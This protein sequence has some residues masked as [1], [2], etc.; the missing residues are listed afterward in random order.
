V[1]GPFAAERWSRDRLELFVADA[2]P[3]DVAYYAPGTVI[4]GGW[5]WLP[6]SARSSGTGVYLLSG[7]ASPTAVVPPFA[8]VGAVADWKSAMLVA[9]HARRLIGVILLR[10][11]HFAVG[12]VD[13]DSV[14]VSRAGH[15]YVH[16]RHRAGGQSQRRWERNREQWIEALFERACGTWEDVTRPFSGRLD[17]L[18]L[19]GDRTVL[20]RFRKSCQAVA[21]LHHIE[22]AR[23]VPVDRPD[24]AAIEKA[25]VAIWSSNVYRTA[26]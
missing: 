10:L 12:V 15:R 17:H 11:G 9:L 8:P 5:D 23:R 22:V 18:A 16:G 24:A 19:G 4:A 21:L 13:N 2:A 6:E 25:R 7:L 1:T 20:A 3:A 26:S 14:L